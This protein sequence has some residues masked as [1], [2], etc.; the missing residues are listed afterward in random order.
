[1]KKILVLSAVAAFVGFQAESVSADPDRNLDIL[2]DAARRLE[3]AL[4][5]NKAFLLI[6]NESVTAP[7]ALVFGYV[8]NDAACTEIIETLN[9]PVRIGTFRCEPIE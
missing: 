1:M 8:D 7:V 3:F 6:K 2:V 5:E 9:D 4:P